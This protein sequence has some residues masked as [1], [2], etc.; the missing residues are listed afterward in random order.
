VM[1][2]PLTSPATVNVTIPVSGAESLPAYQNKP[3]GAT[4]GVIV[5]Q[6]WWGLNVSMQ[7]TTD[8]FAAVGFFAICPDLYRGK[9]AKSRE[10]AGHCSKSLDWGNA[11]RDI[12]VVVAYL[13][14][15]GVGKVGVTGF[16][17]G[18]AL[19]IASAANIPEIAGASCFYGCPDLGALSF[20]NVKYPIQLHFGRLDK[21]AGFSDPATAEKLQKHLEAAGVKADLFMYDADHAFTNRD[22]A[23]VFNEA[24]RNEAFQRTWTYFRS[25]L[26]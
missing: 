14:A 7:K 3:A 11:I 21:A 20:S 2:D 18:G 23:E 8:E 25:V 16:C 13:K 22:R 15:N 24:A 19:T 5:L 9:V 6:E 26:A 17:M 10:E 1:A 12:K 4:M